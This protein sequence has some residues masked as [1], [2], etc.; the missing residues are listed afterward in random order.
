MSMTAT[1]APTVELPQPDEPCQWCGEQ[2]NFWLNHA[3]SPTEVQILAQL[4]QPV[5]VVS[6]YIPRHP[7]RGL[8]LTGRGYVGRHQAETQ[9]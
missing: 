9:R 3:C 6:V 4:N 1:D 8:S 7:K 5:P 2:I